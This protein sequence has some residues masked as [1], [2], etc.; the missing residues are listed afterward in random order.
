MKF[1]CRK[2]HQGQQQQRQQQQAHGRRTCN[3]SALW[4]ARQQD[5]AAASAPLSAMHANPLIQAPIDRLRHLPRAHIVRAIRC[6]CVGA[7]VWVRGWSAS[8]GACVRAWLG[9]LAQNHAHQ[10]KLTQ[11]HD[12]NHQRNSTALASVPQANLAQVAVGRLVAKL[13]RPAVD[14]N[15]GESSRM[16][17][18][19]R[20]CQGW[21]GSAK[22]IRAARTH[23]RGTRQER[24]RG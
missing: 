19:R 23:K 9:V 11:T 21:D 12:H 20:G 5:S 15:S 24:G 7:A 8:V 6:V 18:S 17:R 10:P 13:S 3:C 2:Q 1:A 4:L 14:D 22:A 16:E